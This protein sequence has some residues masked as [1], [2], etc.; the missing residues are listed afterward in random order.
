MCMP[1]FL[2]SF[3]NLNHL[4]IQLIFFNLHCLIILSWALLV[5]ADSICIF[6][7]KFIYL[8]ESE[9]EW[10]SAQA[11]RRGRGRSRL[12]T[13]HGAQSGAGSQDPGIIICPEG[14]RLTDWATQTPLGSIC[15]LKEILISLWLNLLILNIFHC[16]LFVLKNGVISL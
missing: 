11:G 8:R 13:E 1:L 12:P 4:I 7:F 15:T 3:L 5:V 9:P 2:S 10:E 16:I 6:F 14:R